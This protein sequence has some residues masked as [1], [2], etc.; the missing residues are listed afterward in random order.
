[1][2]APAGCR[3]NE[4]MIAP[5]EGSNEHAVLVSKN[6]G[7]V[8]THTG[9]FFN[10]MTLSVIYLHFMSSYLQGSISHHLLRCKSLET[11]RLPADLRLASV[12]SLNLVKRNLKD[13]EYI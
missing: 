9:I 12:A 1:M 4:K 13:V 2:V 6:S 10:K 7:F 11:E 5:P 3:G 8:G